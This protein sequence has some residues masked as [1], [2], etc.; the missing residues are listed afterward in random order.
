MQE[1]N[2]GIYFENAYSGVTLGALVFPHGTILI[3]APLRAE[4]ARS[5]R[6]SL[7]NLSGGA[8]RVLVNLDGHPDRTLGARAVESTIIA[9]QK[10]AQVF[11][12]R[13]TIFKGQAVESG[14]DWESYDDAVGTRWATPDITFTQRLSLHWGPPDVIL[15]HHPGPAPGAIWVIVPE[16]R[17]IF[18]GDAVLAN[19][20]P[21]LANADL[22]S[23]LE[24]LDL[25][26]ASYRDCT[27]VSGRGGTVTV[28][29]VKTQQHNLKNILK[30]MERLAKR[31]APMEATES[32]IAG[33]VGEG[34]Y[35]P[36]LEEHYLH[37]LRYGLSQYYA[38]RYR[39]L[40]M[41]SQFK[42]HEEE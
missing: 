15:E 13:P 38:R 21:F 26:L 31:N 11:R 7:A 4:D 8:S 28:E 2:K 25:L 42:P 27:F 33:L 34:H 9:H 20:P 19:Q 37:R 41:A 39:P 29:A 40:D 24:S 22:P 36:H 18:V 17:V 5:W 30:G 12:S 32:L 16:A 10:T 3:D 1:I 23:W 35:A 6:A 14:A